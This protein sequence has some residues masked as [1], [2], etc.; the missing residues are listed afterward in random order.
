MDNKPK[1]S[2]VIPVYN[3]SNYL[4]EAIDSAL[5]Q[6]YTNYEIIVIDDGSTDTTWD[7]ILLYGDKIR[8]YHKENGGVSSALN[9]G[10]QKMQ[11]KYFTWLSHDDLWLPNKLENQIH[12]FDLN[13]DCKVCYT[14]YLV[15]DF[16]GNELNF[17]DTPWYPRHI[18]IREL[19]K[20]GYINGCTVMI[21]KTCFEKVGFFSENLK[22][23]QDTE[24]WI[25]LSRLYEFRRV[26]EKLIKERWHSQQGSKKIPTHSTEIISMSEDVF[27]SFDVDELFPECQ[28]I[29]SVPKKKAK[30][31]TWFGNTMARYRCQFDVAEK[32]YKISIKVDPSWHNGARIQLLK[33][34]V[35]KF[36]KMLIDIKCI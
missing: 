8:G 2:I 13:P 18:A 10:I 35:R 12:F 36:F 33:N 25:R 34:R 16:L 31:Y 7:I 19:F 4:R 27:L 15:I 3:G 26:P 14:D 20:S 30:A 9:L 6:T 23:T 21:E 5:A 28:Y 24:M 1:V 29:M 22:T 32:Y 11:G 17:I